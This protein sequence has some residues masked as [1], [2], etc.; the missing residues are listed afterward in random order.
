MRKLYEVTNGNK[1]CIN[2]K[3]K[4]T[5]CALLLLSVLSLSLPVTSTATESTKQQLEDARKKKEES[6]GRLEDTKDDL[7]EMHEEKQSLQGQLET[8]NSQLEEVSDNLEDIEEQIEDKV[9]DIENTQTELAAAREREEK[10]YASMKKRIQFMYEKQNNLVLGMFFGADTFSD[11]LNQSNYFEQLS[12][13]DRKMFEVYIDNRK[14][15]EEKE[16]ILLIKN[17]LLN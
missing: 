8:L 3:G 4:R 1:N 11:F 13:Y 14:Y 9:I 7:A 10:Q 2:R 6:Q 12:A 16:A 17:H 15:I 5:V